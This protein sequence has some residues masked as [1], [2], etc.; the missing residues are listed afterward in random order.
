MCYNILSTPRKGTM[1]L[2]KIITIGLL[3]LSVAFIGLTF[4]K[5]E[6]QQKLVEVKYEQLSKT[7]Q[8]QIDCLAKN[9]YHEALGE[10][11]EGW[12]AVGM[13]T[14]NRVESGDFSSSVCGV[15][16]Q[17]VGKSYQFSWVG[18]KKHMSKINLPVYNDILELATLIYMNHERL[19][20]VTDGAT[21]YHADYVN[22][23]WKGLEKTNQIGHHIFY[24]VQDL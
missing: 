21:F 24:K 6:E 19:D 16:H 8:K 15:V 3:S 9:I 22:P 17:K 7:S 4:N 11:K 23:K 18:M 12:M 1:N 14:M 20:D 2:K 5:T 13:V 10:S